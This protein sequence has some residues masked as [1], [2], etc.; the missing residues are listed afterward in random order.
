MM[1]TQLLELNS[2]QAYPDQERAMNRTGA[3]VL[4]SNDGP[5]LSRRQI[6]ALGTAAMATAIYPHRARA[7]SSTTWT[8]GH[9]TVFKIVDAVGPAPIAELFPDAPLA[10][11][12][13]NAD[14][15]VPDFYDPATRALPFSYNVFLVRTPRLIIIVDSGY[16]N[17]KRRSSSSIGNMRHGRFL[18]DLRAAGVKPEQVNFVMNTHF[19]TDHIGWNT[20]LV[21]GK[22]MPTYP[23]ARY[24]FQRAELASVAAGKNG[25]Q[26]VDP[27]ILDSVQPIM[28]ANRADVIDG[29]HEIGDGVRLMFTPGHTPGHHCLEINSRGKRALFTGDIFHSPIQMRYPDWTDRYDEDK[30]A[31]AAQRAK[32]I[33]TASD[34]DVTIFAA[35]FGG[36]TAGKIVSGKGGKRMFRTLSP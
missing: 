29:D 33:D 20:R 25:V 10:A 35:H 21:N 19:H 15:L 1:R 27:A 28:D 3:A 11:F 8:F 34:G 22:W 17:D 36:P 32:I 6:L 13:D 5:Q 12:A 31:A 23:N 26:N 14:W 18:E 30:P 16:G 24:L 9:V 7:N 4:N 2:F